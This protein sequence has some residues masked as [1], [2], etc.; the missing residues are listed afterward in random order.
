VT[1]EAR[2]PGS[3][4]RRPSHADKRKALQRDHGWLALFSTDPAMT[5]GEILAA[6]DR[7]SIEQDFHDLKELDR[8][9]PSIGPPAVAPET[10]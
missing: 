7:F 1:P 6:A 9:S 10:N 2:R 5:A 4:L 3:G 8:P